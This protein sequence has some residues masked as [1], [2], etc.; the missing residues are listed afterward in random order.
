MKKFAFSQTEIEGL[1]IVQ[2]FVSEDLRG[3]FVKDYSKEVF[4]ANGLE[5]DLMEVFYT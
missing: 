4:E 3:S 1:I 2:P 5:H